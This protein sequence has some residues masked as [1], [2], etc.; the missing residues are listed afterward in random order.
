MLLKN[1][2]KKNTLTISISENTKGEKKLKII[3]KPENAQK[4]SSAK[5]ETISLAYQVEADYK[6]MQLPTYDYAVPKVISGTDFQGIKK[7]VSSSKTLDIKMQGSH[8]L[9]F[10]NDS[11]CVYGSKLKFGEKVD[12]D[13]VEDED[14]DDGGEDEGGEGG[15]D[16]DYKDTTEIYASSFHSSIFTY[17]IKL[18]GLASS[19]QFYAPL[20]NNRI[21]LKI[22]MT[23]CL[24]NSTMGEIHIYVKNIEVITY[25][26]E[27]KNDNENR[28]VIKT[29]PR[30]NRKK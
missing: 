1:I 6:I 29:K 12:S 4:G 7:L 14:E 13:Y 23:A 15:E 18:P 21:P 11:G 3:I 28:K 30:K 9:K 10:S 22:C 2:K 8:Y 5:S 24:Q 19:I 20:G 26:S 27:L 17:L 16:D 25:E